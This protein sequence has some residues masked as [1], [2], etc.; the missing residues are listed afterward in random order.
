MTWTTRFA[1]K[2]VG[3]QVTFANTVDYAKTLN[4]GPAFT[5][6]MF[7]PGNTTGPTHS[8]ICV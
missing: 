2:S 7:V 3:E 8:T 1:R 5:L 6:S 4:H